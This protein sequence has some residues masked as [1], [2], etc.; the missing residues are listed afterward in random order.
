MRLMPSRSACLTR[1]QSGMWQA[2]SAWRRLD[3]WG[4][5]IAAIVFG[6]RVGRSDL[7]GV[8]CDGKFWEFLK[9]FQSDQFTPGRGQ[10]VT[11]NNDTWKKISPAIRSHDDPRQEAL[12]RTSGLPREGRRDS[13]KRMTNGGMARS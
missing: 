4:E 6:C 10:L 13:N 3:P 5:T 1:T 12:S 11:I 2:P 8:G 7:L 9:F